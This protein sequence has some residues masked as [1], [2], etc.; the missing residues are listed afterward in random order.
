V[1]PV[2][3]RATVRALVPADGQAFLD[4]DTAART[5]LAGIG[6]RHATTRRP[7]HAA[8]AL[9]M[10]KNALQPASEMLLARWWF[11]TILDVRKS[12]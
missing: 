7:A 9:R 2:Q 8:L 1:V 3:A 12:S 11:L 5:G 4:D 6:G 10:L